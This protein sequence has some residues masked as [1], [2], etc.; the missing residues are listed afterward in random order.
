M[1]RGYHIVHM[2]PHDVSKVLGLE[3]ALMRVPEVVGAFP[4]HKSRKKRDRPRN[5]NGERRTVRKGRQ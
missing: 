3:R 5:R 2:S 1:T 4:K